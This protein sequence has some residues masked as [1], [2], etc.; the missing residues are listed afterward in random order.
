VDGYG[1]GFLR[2]GARIVLAT[3]HP[4]SPGNYVRQL[5]TTDRTMAE[6]FRASPDFR[7][8]VLGSYPSSRTPGMRYLLDPDRNIIEVNGAA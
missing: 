6:M 2:A 5:F 3:G 8:H 7:N 1:A 4:R